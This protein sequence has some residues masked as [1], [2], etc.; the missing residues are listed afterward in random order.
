MTGN[1]WV[2]GVN[3]EK[4]HGPESKRDRGRRESGKEI[5]LSRECSKREFGCRAIL[6]AS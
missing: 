6:L 5:R 2:V 1:A 3:K 4:T